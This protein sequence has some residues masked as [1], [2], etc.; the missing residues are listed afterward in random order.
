VSCD[1]LVNQLFEERRGPITGVAN[2]TSGGGWLATAIGA[3]VE[4]PR[5]AL[6]VDVA[7]REYAAPIMGKKWSDS[8][9]KVVGIS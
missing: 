1:Y 9:T 6:A 5:V 3:G 7:C 8:V 2:T 4:G